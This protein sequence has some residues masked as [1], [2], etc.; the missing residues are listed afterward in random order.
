MSQSSHQRRC[1]RCGGPMSSFSVSFFNIEEVCMDCKADERLAPG[2]AAAQAAEEAAV[3]RG[4]FNFPGVG[5]S[6]ADDAFLAER[7]AARRRP[8][9][10]EKEE[11]DG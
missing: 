7:R 9:A 4:D 5:L 10:G 1:P 8:A 3:Q 11:S 2:F 6:A